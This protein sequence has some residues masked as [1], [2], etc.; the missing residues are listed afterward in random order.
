[1]ISGLLLFL[2]AGPSIGPGVG[3]LA[4]REQVRGQTPVTGMFL[5]PPKIPDCRTKDESDAAIAA[6]RAGE[7]ETCDP[8]RFI[9]AHGRSQRP[10]S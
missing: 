6:K 2:A 4:E 8:E 1:M 5:I 10:A 9:R 7:W 3:Q